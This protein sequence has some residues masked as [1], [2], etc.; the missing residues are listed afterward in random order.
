MRVSVSW[1]T[2]AHV[3][4]TLRL[5]S[6][7]KK[8]SI[9]QTTFSNAFCRMKMSKKRIESHWSLLLRF[10]L[11]SQIMAWCRQATSHYLNQWWLAYRRRYASL[12]LNE[13]K[14]NDFIICVKNASCLNWL[15]SVCTPV[16]II[17]QAVTICAQVYWMVTIVVSLWC[18]ILG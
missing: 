2:E 13:L 18:H 7:D 15:N 17:K 9:F 16:C 8:V 14:C 6:R 10:T 12:G 4:A 1:N 11:T 5:W 3:P